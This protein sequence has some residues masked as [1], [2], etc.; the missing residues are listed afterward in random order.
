MG[1]PDSDSSASQPQGHQEAE[2]KLISTVEVK[3]ERKLRARRQPG[4]SVWFGFGMFGMVGWSIALPTIACLAI[5][6]WIDRRWP[7]QY[8]WTLMFLFIGIVLG[9]LNGWYWIKRER[10]QIEQAREDGD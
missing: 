4:N 6:I 10:N 9:C 2:D 1:N 3:E 8:S 5:G 7:S